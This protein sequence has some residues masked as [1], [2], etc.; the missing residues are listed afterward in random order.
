MLLLPPPGTKVL[1]QGEEWELEGPLLENAIPDEQGNRRVPIF[2]RQ[3][4]AGNGPNGSERK[5]A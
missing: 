4:V 2:L 3:T 1:W 5:V